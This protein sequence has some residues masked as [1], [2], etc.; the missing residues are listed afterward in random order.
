MYELGAAIACNKPVVI[1]SCSGSHAFPFDIRHRAVIEYSRDSTSDFEKLKSEITK[2]LLAILKTQA[3]VQEIVTASPVKS[4]EG[5]KPSEITALAFIMANRDYSD[6]NVR[7]R[8]IRDD[9]ERAG[10][11][12]LATGLALT[13]LGRKGLVDSAQDGSGGFNE[14][15]W[16]VYRLTGAG[17]DWLLDNQDLLEL[18]R[19][20]KSAQK[21]A[22]PMLITDDDVPF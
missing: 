2:K 12:D 4:T 1:I 6:G 16:T 7:Y 21:R 11:T 13:A 10:Y 8:V 15:I 22:N 18:R 3:E 14:E 9:M 19:Q 20:P 5:L 17:E